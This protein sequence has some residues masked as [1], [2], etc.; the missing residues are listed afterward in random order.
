M[1]VAALRISGVRDAA[2]SSFQ[3]H[4]CS[5]HGIQIHYGVTT[6]QLCTTRAM[7]PATARPSF[8]A[9]LQCASIDIAD[10]AQQTIF[11]LQLNTSFIGP[12][13]DQTRR[14]LA[15]RCTCCVAVLQ[16][17]QSHNK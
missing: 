1:A 12:L 9:W 3:V 8:I 6:P 14:L 16:L 13:S 15:V 11:Q 2:T 5:L 17:C 7:C 10:V 4:E